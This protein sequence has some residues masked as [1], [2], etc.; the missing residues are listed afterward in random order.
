MRSALAILGCGA[1]TAVGLDANQTC[2]A[3]RAGIS[4]VRDAYPMPPPAEPLLGA[5]IPAG[6]SLKKTPAAWLI[7]LAAKAINECLQH[8]NSS[9]RAALFINLPEVERRHLGLREL[10]A[11]DL[12][13]K[14]QEK[15][16]RKFI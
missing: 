1:V 10:S 7:N 16:R 13:R 5:P 6:A 12:V 15:C 3:I 14:I 2:A 11:E 8:A 4:G 9:D